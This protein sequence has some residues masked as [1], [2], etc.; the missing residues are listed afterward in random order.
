MLKDESLRDLKKI[1]F[2]S[3][4]YFTSLIIVRFIT[5][6]NSIYLARFLLSE[7]F[8]I[9]SLIN[10]LINLLTFFMGFGIPTIIT[11]FIAQTKNEKKI[12]E[13]TYGTA[14]VLI[15]LISSFIIF[16][17]FF[18]SIPLAYNIYQ[19]PFL[20]K[21]FRLIIFLLFFI[22]FNNFWTGVL[23]GLKA[24]KHISLI[25][26][27]YNLVSFPLIFIFAHRYE[28][29]GAIIALTLAN[30]LGVILF[31]I[32]IKKFDLLKT[33]FQLPIVKNIINLSFP[34]FLSGLVM[35]PALWLINTKLAIVKNFSEVAYFNITNT[36]FQF[37]LFIPIAIGMPLTPTIAEEVNNLEKIKFF[38]SKIIN[39]LNFLF[40]FLLILIFSFSSKIIF[41][42]FGKDYLPAIKAFL[43]VIG[44]II[45]A[46]IGYIFGYYLTGTGKMW[47]ATFFNGLW[48]FLLV[49]VFFLF[50][51]KW[52]ALGAGISFYIAYFFQAFLM[53]IYF[54]NLLKKPLF[55]L[56]ILILNLIVIII[57]YKLL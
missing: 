5:A 12:L 2:Q 8:G 57:F 25:T 13:K 51:Y 42:I 19:K 55:I 9:Y 46:S 3:L 16:I 41:L 32:T 7:K 11:K 6:L 39:Y 45:P 28:L 18:I 49:G 40:L 27:I 4:Q 54:R 37:L 31:L 35:V 26:G 47:L 36:F 15:I 22:T 24:I 48:F 50:N 30:L 23:Q 17:Y 29:V 53:I 56:K 20:L 38:L 34:T 14:Q 44:S 1:F 43:F 52:G 33:A 10:Q 21:Y